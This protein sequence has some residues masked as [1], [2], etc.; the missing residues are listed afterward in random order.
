MLPGRDKNLTYRSTILSKDQA[1]SRFGG[2]IA[3]NF[4]VVQLSIVNKGPVKMQVPLASIQAEVEW[5]SGNATVEKGK[6]KYY[7]EGPTTVAPVPL[8]GA[9]SYFSTYRDA[10]G[11]RARFFNILQGVTTIGSAIQLFFGPGF[12]QAVGIAG[13]GLRQGLDQIFKDMSAQ[14]L[15]NLTSQSFESIE[16]V[17]GNGGSIE[18]VIFI[19]RGE[20]QLESGKNVKFG[21]L[22]DNIRGFEINGYEAPETPAK[23]ATPQQP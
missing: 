3:N 13:G 22:I 16:T 19:Q 12:A 1:S 17:S 11:R 14:Q 2:G 4:Y 15:A 18:K 7:L 21:R 23:A 10:T 5:L 6:A 9:V 8:A 20:E